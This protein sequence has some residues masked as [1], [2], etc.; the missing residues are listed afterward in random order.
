MTTPPEM[1]ERVV[2]TSGVC[3]RTFLPLTLFA[4]TLFAGSVTAATAEHRDARRW[5]S[6]AQQTANPVRLLMLSM[7]IHG[8]LETAVAKEPDNVEARLDLVRF[9]T[10]TPS[11]AGGSIEEARAQAAEI[12]RRDA[13]L[14]HFAS[15]YIAYR[16]KQYGPA[17]HELREA[18][19]TGPPSTRALAARWLGWLSQESQQW[20]EAFAS[21]ESL[22]GMEASA[23]YEI[24]RTA[25][26]CGCERERGRKALEEY[27]GTK[28]ANAKEARQLL[29]KLQ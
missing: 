3:L 18:V 28:P 1:P 26:F 24:G 20:E 21:F 17:R 27:L 6:E 7:K 23:L 2:C 13:P 12:A 25:V 5:M 9:Y 4:V 15:G 11:L 10:M 14:G 29:A 19:R 8:A 16:E 22:R